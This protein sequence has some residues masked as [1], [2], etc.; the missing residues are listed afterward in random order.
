MAAPTFPY[1]HLRHENA[2]IRLLTLRPGSLNDPIHCELTICSLQ[3]APPYKALSYV[4]GDA[5]TSS[6][7]HNTILL[8]GHR[9]SVTQNL[10][11][12]L[13]HL[14]P[15]D[16]TAPLT[17]WVDAICINQANV[18]E[19]NRQVA[20]MRQIYAS[21]ERVIIWLGGD[22][23]YTADG[24]MDIIREA[25]DLAQVSSRSEHPPA[26][27][28]SDLLRQ[29]ADFYFALAVVRPWFSRVWIIQE[30]AM[31]KRDPLV[32]IGNRSVSWTVLVGVWNM[33][34]EEILPNLGAENSE[35][36]ANQNTNKEVGG[37]GVQ[38]NLRDDGKS[39]RW[40]KVKLDVLDD[41]FRSVQQK[42]GETLRRLLI[43]SRTSQSTDPKDKVYALL[44]LLSPAETSAT[45][46]IPI[47]IDYRK[48]TWEVFSDATSHIFSRGEGPYFLS[49]IFLP[50]T[51]IP[52][53][54]PSWVPDL[55][56]Q[57]SETATQPSGVQ[58]HPPAG[59]MGASGMGAECM[60]GYRLSD[61]RTLRVEGLFID[62][63]DEIIPLGESLGELVRRLP[64][65]DAVA[66]TARERPYVKDGAT[67]KA[68]LLM[69]G[70]KRNEPLWKTLICSK[71]WMS[72]Y[73][74][75][76]VEY[77][78][79]YQRL[80]HGPDHPWGSEYK[81]D[82]EY[83]LALA[84]GIH[85]KVLFTTTGGLVGVCIPDG[86]PG[87]IITL[88]FGSPVPFVLRATGQTV[89]IAGTEKSVHQLVGASYVGGIMA[90]E[91]VDELYCEDLIDSMSFYVR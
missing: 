9:F 78:D 62:V 23:E 59:I 77:G 45:G 2:E 49:G 42:G 54:L 13:H 50:G 73:H 10:L 5:A 81:T 82:N 56:R 68:C 8:E 20:V 83:E 85:Q 91:M 52:N 33:I 66:K 41:L 86:R 1:N 34:A 76:P 55:S 84:Q 37:D 58:F 61:K 70:F 88:W 21:A 46:S 47:P 60:N 79:M 7:P 32:L 40:S 75:A 64:F 48:Q 29:C 17:L 27:D 25:N 31:A 22:D 3:A 51:S 19:R 30:L 36:Q 44:G 87:D 80:L 74:M 67:T 57:T 43:I 11:L 90:G 6:H 89:S 26:K 63:I 65:V 24:V 38:K 69:E 72:G 35:Q 53:G 4:W 12:A 28:L 18:D 39:D 14:R 71:S 16:A 15:Q